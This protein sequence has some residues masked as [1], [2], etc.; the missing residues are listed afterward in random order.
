MEKKRK[1]SPAPVGERVFPLELVHDPV[2]ENVQ[3]S[4]RV[5]E[6]SGNFGQPALRNHQH[7]TS[8]QHQLLQNGVD[9]ASADITSDRVIDVSDG[10]FHGHSAGGEV[11]PGVADHCWR[12]RCEHKAVA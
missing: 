10:P 4:I 7:V 5:S 12:V 8:G 1:R 11:T 3:V 6:E 2:V 9:E